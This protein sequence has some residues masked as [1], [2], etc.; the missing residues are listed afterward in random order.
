MQFAT[1]A[2]ARIATAAE[3]LFDAERNESESATTFV[4]TAIGYEALY[5]GSKG[6]PVVQTLANRFAYSL[7][8][9]PQSRE[10]L[11]DWFE[12]FYEVRSQVVHNGASRLTGKQRKLLSI[13]LGLLRETLQHELGLVSAAI[14]HGTPRRLS[15]LLGRTK[16]ESTVRYLGIEVDDALEMAE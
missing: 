16:L 14:H 6:E 2:S 1:T 4:Q 9:T 5:G 10:F 3:W 11:R 7:G 12:E 13:M 8:R 15:K